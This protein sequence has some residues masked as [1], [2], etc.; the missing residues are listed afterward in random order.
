[1]LKGEKIRQLRKERGWT[2]RELGMRCGL[3]PAHLSL[4]ENCVLTI[5]AQYLA[6]LSEI[7][8]VTL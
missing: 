2:Q 4:L 8:G 7:F 1:M 5:K 3:K 6:K